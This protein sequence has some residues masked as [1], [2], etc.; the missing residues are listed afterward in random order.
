VLLIVQAISN[1][2]TCVLVLTGRIPSEPEHSIPQG[3]VI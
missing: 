3:E 1:L 2:I